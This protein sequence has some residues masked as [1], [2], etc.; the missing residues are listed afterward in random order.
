L[1]RCV[2]DTARSARAA[3]TLTQCPTL[4]STEEIAPLT[5]AEKAAKLAE[6]RLAPL[7]TRPLFGSVGF[8]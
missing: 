5:E 2:Q 8:G 4:K 7:S 1:K 3:S 6:V